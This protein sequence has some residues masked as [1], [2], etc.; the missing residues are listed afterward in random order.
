[1]QHFKPEPDLTL[2]FGTSATSRKVRELRNNPRATVTCLDPRQPAYAVLSGVVTMEAQ[3]RPWWRYWRD[4]WQTVWP[5]G[6]TGPD[7]LL[8]R[9][10]CER[11]EV[12]SVEAGIVPPPYGWRAPVVVRHEG[13]WQLERL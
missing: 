1:M 5:A 10:A 2:W 9:F 8:L 12:L 11:V 4:E 13:G 7:Y 6:P 3:A